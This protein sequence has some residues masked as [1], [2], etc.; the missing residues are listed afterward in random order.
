[1]QCLSSSTLQ[2][3]SNVL[4]QAFSTRRLL[5]PLHATCHLKSRKHSVCGFCWLDH[6]VLP[7]IVLTDP[8]IMTKDNGLTLVCSPALSLLNDLLTTKHVELQH[9]CTT[10]FALTLLYLFSHDLALSEYFHCMQAFQRQETLYQAPLLALRKFLNN[11]PLL[12]PES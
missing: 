2:H 3:H 5:S 8:Y 1:M 4:L 11:A 12:R 10:G 7:R 9:S 6:Q